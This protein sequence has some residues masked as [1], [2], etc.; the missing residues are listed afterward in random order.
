MVGRAAFTVLVAAW[1]QACC[2]DERKVVT[3]S[4]MAKERDDI[5]EGVAG[6]ND[7]HQSS[8]IHEW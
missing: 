7:G 4:D 3:V 6:G 5:S 1:F 8:N 2:K